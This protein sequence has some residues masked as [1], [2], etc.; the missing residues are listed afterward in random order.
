MSPEQASGEREVDARSDVYA[1]GTVLYEMLTGEPP[2]T[3]SSTQAVIA[4][5]F[6]S[7]APAV[8]VLRDGVPPGVTSAVATAL[9]Q[10]S[11]P[12]RHGSGISRRAG[13]GASGGAQQLHQRAAPGRTCESPVASGSRRS[14]APAFSSSGGRQPLGQWPRG[15]AALAVLPFENEGDTANAYFVDGITDEIRG[16]LAA[17]PALQVIAR[18]SSNEYRQSRKTAEQIGRELG[19]QYLLTGT[20]QS[21]RGPGGTRR[22]RVS[23]ELVQVGAR[24]APVTKWHQSYDT[25]LANVFDLQSAVATRV[26]EKLGVVLSPLAKTQLAARP[27][28]N[29][30]AY[31]AYLRSLALR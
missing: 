11:R 3:G 25:T 31:D 17:L 13:T 16:K 27:T 22:V 28:Q 5:R 15:P 29:V 20:V 18:T 24:R 30:D 21:E 4:K 1:L 19:V 12:L 23:P 9:A 14:S 7:A 2:F 8:S 10:P 6:A 26:A